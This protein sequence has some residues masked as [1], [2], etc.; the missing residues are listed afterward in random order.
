MTLT[1]P[2]RLTAMA[3]VLLAALAQG[4]G[5]QA[6]VVPPPDAPPPAAVM[7]QFGGGGFASAPPLVATFDKDADGRLN[8][9]ERQAAL[10]YAESLGISRRGGR[11]MAPGTPG[12]T[13]TPADVR[14]YP[15]TPFYDNATIR[16]LFLTFED[17][18]WERQLMA[19]WRTDVDV[20]ATLT[21]DG[22]AYRDVGIQFHGNSSFAG[23]PM[24]LKHSMNVS[25]DYVRENQDVESYNTLLLLN[26]HEDPSFLRTILAH[27]IAREYIPAPKANLVRVVINGE[28]WGLYVSQQHFNKDLLREQFGTTD[29]ARW[30]VSGTRAD[31]GSG[32]NYLGDD[33]AAYRYAYEIKTKDNPEDWAALVHMTRVLDTTPPERL[34]AALAPLLDIDGALKF[35]AV[36]IALVNGDGYWSKASD[37]SLYRHPDGRFHVLPYDVNAT[38]AATSRGASPELDPLQAAYDPS[39]PLAARL[40]AVPALRQRYLGYVRDIATRWLDWNTL[41]PIVDRH[42]ALVESDIAADTRKI[43]STEAFAYSLEGL[44]EY[45]SRRRAFLLAATAE[46]SLP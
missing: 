20:P 33:V 11:G 39:K 34:E 9:E 35:L 1:R 21:V 7:P 5:L 12:R 18:D 27:Q 29:G 31:I 23:V 41:G 42:I 24:G 15:S 45:A 40:L 28:S 2:L 6:R 22:R 16:T 43:Y 17:E 14:P 8:A 13:M 37:Y 38:L 44:R 25:L 19:F 10:R 30:K 4:R 32:L 3:A 46:P 36:D 26:A